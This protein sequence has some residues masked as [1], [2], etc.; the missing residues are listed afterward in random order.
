MQ[1][2][3]QTCFNNNAIVFIT[4]FL[5]FSC[6]FPN[7]PKFNQVRG[8]G[9]IVTKKW[10]EDCHSQRKRLPWRRYALDRNDHGKPESEEEILEET[11]EETSER[12]EETVGEAAEDSM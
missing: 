7:T 10:I 2:K 11:E 9:K 12:C 8:K 3:T 1:N 6:A 5:I 4:L